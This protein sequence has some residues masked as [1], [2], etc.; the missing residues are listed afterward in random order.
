MTAG[1]MKSALI[2]KY[3]SWH[4]R[5]NYV[6]SA[7]ESTMRFTWDD[8]KNERNIMIHEIDLKMQQPYLN[9]TCILSMT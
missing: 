6:Y 3:I 9:K 1:H 5:T 7:K 8:D 4:I 2:I